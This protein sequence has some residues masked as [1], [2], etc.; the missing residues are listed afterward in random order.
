MC[1]E[2]NTAVMKAKREEP[3]RI[4]AKDNILCDKNRRK[5]VIQK[6]KE[7]DERER[8]VVLMKLWMLL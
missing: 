8:Q 2:F 5:Q 4:F 7:M 6:L 3:T 1:Q